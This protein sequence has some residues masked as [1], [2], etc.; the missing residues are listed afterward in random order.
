[1]SKKKRTLPVFAITATM[2]SWS[3]MSLLL[4]M[5]YSACFNSDRQLL[6]KVDEYG[7]MRVEAVIFAFIWI[8]T[9][10]NVI[11]VWKRESNR[12]R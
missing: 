12:S 10:L 1:M 7:E 11:L 8:M 4:V 5:F 9:T 3:L 6:I 2:L